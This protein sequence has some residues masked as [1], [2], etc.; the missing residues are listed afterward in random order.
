M[1]LQGVWPRLFQ[2]LAKHRPWWST[3]SRGGLEAALLDQ[4]THSA[5]RPTLQPSQRA[6]TRASEQEQLAPWVRCQLAQ[7]V[8]M[9]DRDGA[10]KAAQGRGRPAGHGHDRQVEGRVDV[11]GQTSAP[12][13]LSDLDA[14][15]L[16][17]PSRQCIV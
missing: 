13:K 15:D 12:A 7:R 9:R 3:V 14:R 11:E 6:G 1:D 2:Q 16:V 4:R 10:C 8:E 5:A 17:E